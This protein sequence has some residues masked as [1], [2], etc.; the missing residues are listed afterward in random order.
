MIQDVMDT[1][2]KVSKLF[3]PSKIL[4]YDF[5][6]IIVAPMFF[7]EISHQLFDLGIEKEKIRPYYEN[8]QEFYSHSEREFNNV[9]IGKYSYFKPTTRVWHCDI[10]NFC[11]IGS[12]WPNWSIRS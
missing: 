12:L 4:M 8:Y 5:D 9:K 3:H 6:S 10:G 1:I 2:W 7:D 11:H